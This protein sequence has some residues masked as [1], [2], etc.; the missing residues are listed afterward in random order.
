MVDFLLLEFNITDTNIHDNF[1]ILIR[2][3]RK[4]RA[5]GWLEILLLEGSNNLFVSFIN[6]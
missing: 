2:T 4:K 6:K 3:G 1:I 5:C